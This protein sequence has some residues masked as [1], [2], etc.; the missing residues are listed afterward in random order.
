MTPII[1]VL[2]PNMLATSVT[3]PLE[4]L[5]AAWEMAKTQNPRL[6]PLS[7]SYRSE[8]G[9]PV[10]THTG[11]TLAAEPLELNAPRESL[12]FLPAL[13]RNPVKV[14]SR[15]PG[16]RRW[17]TNQLQHQNPTVAAVGTGVCLLAEI[18]ALDG[19]PA[20]THWHFF[21][22]FVRRYPKVQ[23]KRDLFITRHQRIFCT[24]S[25]N[26]LAELTA[27][28]IKEQ[29]GLQIAQAVERNFFHEIRQPRT[30]AGLS[31][32]SPAT[33]DELVALAMAYLDDQL[34]N[35]IGSPNAQAI[36]INALADT[37]NVSVRSLN[38]HF[39]RTLNLSPLQY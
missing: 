8:T 12:I 5:R 37:L 18:G 11:L 17:L 7:V 32:H 29:Y 38:R 2:C 16:L 34:D 28:F 27:F 26:A 9:E 15:Q 10:L 20:T 30:Q 33:T 14:V 39:Q 3:L 13:W 22:S 23:L 25:I 1:F 31:A 36:S 24:A 4:M 21:D 35:A 19:K 6:P